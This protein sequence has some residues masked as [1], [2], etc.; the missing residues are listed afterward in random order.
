MPE[1]VRRSIRVGRPARWTAA[2][3]ISLS[4]L[5][6]VALAVARLRQADGILVALA[7]LGAAAITFVMLAWA[8]LATWR[9]PLKDV[10][11]FVREL[12]ENRKAR[13]SKVAVPE[14]AELTRE[15]M[16]LAK[17]I[18]APPSR[19]RA[20][21]PARSKSPP[22]QQ[23]SPSEASLTHSGLFDAP[24]P[25]QGRHLDPTLSGDYSTSDMVNRLDPLG[26]RWIE[27]STAE[28]I[29]LGWTL[30]ELRQRTFLEVVHPDDRRRTEETFALALDRG[31]ALG[32]IVKLRTAHGK[33]RTVEVNVGAR[34]GTKQKVTHLRCHLTDVT[35]KVRAER[36]LRLRTLELTQ[37]NEQLRQ[38][39]RELE[40]LKDRYSD[41]YENAPAM[42]FSLDLQ[43]MVIECNQTMLA[44]LNKPRDAVVGHT[45]ETFLHGPLAERFKAR[46][47]EFLRKGSVD[48]ETRW[49]K[50]SGEI[51]DIWVMGSVV[52]SPKGAM[53]HARF[54]AQDITAKRRLEAEIH[55][56]NQRLAQANDELSQRNRELDEFV[57]VVSHD[58]QEPLR[59]LI[60]F[61]DFLLRDYGDRL[62]AEGQEHVR[63]LVD[64][65]RRMRA[66]IHGMLNLSRVGKVIGEF[67]WVDL[68]E[69]V[70]V[71]KTDLGELFR[72]KGGELRLVSP[73]PKI[74]G[75]HDRI[76]QLLANLIS[77][78]IKYNKSPNPWVEI[79]AVEGAGVGSPGLVPD[80]N[81][82]TDVTIAISDNGIGIEPRFH[83]TIFQ[84]F[85]RLHTH[86]EYEGTGV[87]LAICSKIVLAHG[88]RIWVESAL[89]EGATFFVRLRGGPSSTTT[90]F[91]L[92]A[93]PPPYEAAVSQ[94]PVDEHNA[95]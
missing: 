56:K 47:Q 68:D 3:L 38:I 9:Q 36:E 31:E 24:P 76:G 13:P 54:V 19:R 35:D 21:F 83:S 88:G 42:Y 18:H 91:S 8:D 28:Q 87:G 40:E 61:S 6:V 39:N 37:V 63:Y 29:L 66:M 5:L 45:Y 20:A 86:D 73:L 89:G 26:F 15:I 33:T 59:T 94:V 57:Y 27:S 7:G 64:A 16:A 55:E 22:E 32:L 1:N 74:W 46:F 50:S 69:L 81:S 25:V 10:T 65:S 48:K 82:L 34:Y 43:A 78:G 70:A 84:L 71:I 77:N 75:D 79:K 30:E 85:R 52:V 58:L 12:R 2:C 11:S 72:S 14:L 49:V 92:T 17:G 67:D 90:P 41:L 62:E 53:T 80:V 44:T 51:I 95:R 60:A 93:Q 23:S 4:W